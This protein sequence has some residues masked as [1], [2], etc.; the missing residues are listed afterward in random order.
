MAEH[1][2]ITSLTS[3]KVYVFPAGLRG[4]NYNKSKFTTEDN[5]ILFSK[6][7]ANYKNLNRVYANPFGDGL[8]LKLGG[9]CFTVLSEDLKKQFTDNEEF[10]NSNIYAVITLVDKGTGIGKVLANVNPTVATGVNP[11][12]AGDYIYTLDLKDG[13]F[14]KFLGLLFVDDNGLADIAD[15]SYYKTKSDIEYQLESI[16]IKESGSTEFLTQKLALDASEIRN[17]ENSDESLSEALDTETLRVKT[18]TNAVSN[19]NPIQFD[20]ENK[21]GKTTVNFNSSSNINII[22]SKAMQIYSA[23]NVGDAST[24]TGTVTVKSAGTGNTTI[25][26]PSSGIIN[27][28]ANYSGTSTTNAVL[29]QTGSSATSR[30]LKYDDDNTSNTLVLRDGNNINST[31]FNDV[32]VTKGTNSFNIWSGASTISSTSTKAYIKMNGKFTVASNVVASLNSSIDIAANAAVDIDVPLNI[33]ADGKT[34]GVNISS[35]GSNATT[36]IGPSGGISILPDSA[37]VPQT[38]AAG[39][40]YIWAQHHDTSGIHTNSWIPVSAAANQPNVIVMT[41]ANG[42]I[43]A[44][45][46]GEI[47]K[48]TTVKQITSTG[49]SD[50]PM[51]FTTSSTNGNY[52]SIYYNTGIKVN[53]STKTITATN[54][55]GTATHATKIGVT[56]SSTNADYPLLATDETGTTLKYIAAKYASTSLT[57]NPSTGKLNA[58]IISAA[59]SIDAPT[60]TG[61]TEI[62]TPKLTATAITGTLT[63][64]ASTAT[65]FS[66]DASVTLTG[67]VTGTASSKK[68]W[69]IATTI[70]NSGVTANSYGLASAATPGFGSSFNV[71]YFTVNSKGLITAASTKTVK[72][73]ATIATYNTLGLVKPA[74]TTT[75]E[76][77]FQPEAKTVTDTPTISTRTTDAN[78]YYAVEADK[79]G[80]LFVNVPWVNTTY[81]V[82]GGAAGGG[83]TMVDGAFSHSHTIAAKTAKVSSNATPAFGGTFDIYETLYDGYGHVT[84]VGTSTITIPATIATSSKPGLVQTG[85]SAS[86]K[87]YAVKLSSNKMYVTV[88]W[89]DTLTTAGRVDKSATKLYLTGVESQKSD[90]D[91]ADSATT[92]TN[93][94]VYIGS[95]NQLYSNGVQ[96]V[97]LSGSQALTNK[98]YNG[99]TLAAACAKGVTDS[100]AAGALSTGS[101][102]VTERDVYYGTPKINNSKSYT[103]STTIYA[104]TTCGTANQILIAAGS[105]KAPTWVTN[106]SV[107]QGGTGLTTLTSGSALIGNGTGAV[108]LRAITNNTSATAVTASTNLITANTLYYHTGNSN[109]TTLGTITTGTWQGS[110]ISATYLPTASSSAKGVMKVGNGLTSSSGTVSLPAMTNLTAASYGPSSNAT[111]THSGTFSV[112]NFTVD[113]YGRLTAASAITYTLPSSGNTDK[114][115][116]QTVTGDTNTS[117]RPVLIGMSFS[118]ASPKAFA[119]T[120]DTCYAAHTV[121]IE[122]KS[123]K[124]TAT[125][126]GGDGSALTSLNASNISSGT[127]AKER[128][129]TSGVTAGSYGNSSNQTPGYGSTFNVPYIT[130]DKYGRVTSISNKTVKIPDTDNSNTSHNHSAGVGLT[131]SGSAGTSSGTYTYKVN[132]VNETAS[133][134]A[135][136]YT[137]GGS[138]KFYAVQLDKD[139]K[140]GVYVPWSN[141]TYTFTDHNPTLAWETKSKVATVGGTA[142]HVTMPKNPNTD[143]NVKQSL[144]ADDVNYPVI[145]KN[146]STN[147]DSPTTGVNYSASVYVN[148]KSG[149]ITAQTFNALSDAR[150]KENFQLLKL[151]GKSILDLPVYK[152]DFKDGSLKNQIGCK[153]QD[154]QEICPEI[155]SENS[156]GFLTIQESKIVYLLL[157]EVKQLKAEIEALKNK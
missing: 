150:R 95:D 1:K 58:K 157:E 145:L 89:T 81:S 49:N 4:S 46:E 23:L 60:I 10:K 118:D 21:F 59:T 13:N 127:L 133:T 116:T 120:T 12:N 50:Y 85:Y 14:D 6:L 31:T 103:S 122:P 91:T 67:D 148:A 61:S 80:R 121:W 112:P 105:S 18:I 70:K 73:P 117:A 5:L 93:A 74:Y 106:L 52:V 24:T 154:L 90:T 124:L 38:E 78:R 153:A 69:S 56:P 149:R 129:A 109:I 99:Y 139:S 151:N 62:T 48:A 107:S 156:D 134:N 136:S 130:V 44:T 111:L 47:N 92:Y 138:S 63:G 9:Y 76:A 71:P 54:F 72:I 39:Y 19:P 83:L 37:A 51:L 2:I 28:P 40:K 53:P 27:L 125:S 88:P 143:A 33:G 131:G 68:G 15:N 17:T 22:I 146:S 35:N 102:L 144:K 45:V 87:N 142:I 66:A 114:K 65:Q 41:D 110:T 100:T 26:G 101:N 30:W 82:E 135:A 108:N 96:V 64:N 147:T 3:D 140:L 11:E 137:A 123:G 86:G 119:T 57:I 55:A 8:I 97:N 104:P 132:L 79:N 7:S 75:G 77:T 128:L 29:A 94:N 84:G 34:G 20:A 152:F 113:S 155:V 16:K 25:I 42:K 32:Y 115:V 43:N 126:F 141:T 36:I 98:T